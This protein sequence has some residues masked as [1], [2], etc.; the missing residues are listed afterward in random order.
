M[1]ICTKCKNKKEL[2]DFYKSKQSK[3]GHR[4][5]CK[6]CDYNQTKKNRKD[7]CPK[8]GSPKEKRSLACDSC[9][10]RRRN[11]K[12]GKTTTANGYIY[13]Y[14]PDHPEANCRGYVMEHRLVMEEHLGRFLKLKENVHHKNGI[15]DDNTISN[16]ELWTKHQPTGSRVEDLLYFCANFLKDYGYTTNYGKTE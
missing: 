7:K 3:D 5:Q 6:T 4:W 10:E 11:W 9:A 8:C 14:A 15:R 13:A 1:K 12:G 16:L 2:S